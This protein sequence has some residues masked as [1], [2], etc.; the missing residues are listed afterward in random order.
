M[1]FDLTEKIPEDAIVTLAVGIQAAIV[2]VKEEDIALTYRIL[3]KAECSEE[4]FIKFLL[5]LIH[6]MSIGV[7]QHMFMSSIA[8]MF[9]A[10]DCAL[11]QDFVDK[12][13]KKDSSYYLELLKELENRPDQLKLS[14]GWKFYR[15][16][17][18]ELA[19]RIQ[20]I[21]H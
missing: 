15:N 4:D 20:L 16:M 3:K 12:L 8:Y 2:P 9:L 19:P 5:G 6:K 7:L 21:R 18:E 17:V 13:L 11:G 10:K 1:S 14:K